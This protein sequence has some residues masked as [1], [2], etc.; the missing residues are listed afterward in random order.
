M[1]DTD[2][3]VS[4]KSLP[5]QWRP[6]RK[7]K[8]STLRISDATFEKH[9]YSKPVKRKLKLLEDFDP[10]PLEFRGSAMN[11]LPKLLDSLR[12]EQLCISL[13]FDQTCRR[14]EPV[15]ELQDPSSYHIPD[16][17][18]LQHAIT[19]FKKTL[20]VTQESAREIER[21]TRDQRRSPLWFSL[22]RFRITASNF[23]AVL[24]RRPDTPP[25]SLV[26]RMIQPRNF[27]T[28]AITYG[29]GN[30]QVAIKEYTAYQHDHGHP[31]LFVTQS[32][33][34]IHPSYPYLGAS[35][36]GSLYDP[37]EIQQPFGFLE[38]KCPYSVRQMS[39]TEACST[40]GFFCELDSSTG[41]PKL[42]ESHPYFAQVQGQMGLGERLWC[43][44]VVYTQ[45]SIS[46]Q[47]I[48]FDEAYW[49]NKL[50][51]RLCFMIIVSYLR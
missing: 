35:P 6:P 14:V 3:E 5:C 9:D 31:N 41:Q 42:K 17:T 2:I 4:V 37:S 11:R 25:D 15:E 45:K 10:R 19:A 40:P 26:L 1:D 51:P 33:F 24:S 50:L 29:V 20:E 18:E 30:E 12:G 21:N 27:T 34:Y 13:L 36:D 47:R 28:P 7:R 22:H 38:V 39:P 43:D 32:G 16:S 46:I 23:G 49:K 48:P 44:F 8:E